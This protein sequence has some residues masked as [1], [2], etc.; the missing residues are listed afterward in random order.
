MNAPIPPGTAALPQTWH[1]EADVV[2]VG[3][4]GAGACAAIEAA[5][6]GAEVRVIDRFTG[7]GATAISGGVFYG[8]GGTKIQQEAG[9]EDTI[10]D[11]FRYLEFEVGEAVTKDTL[12]HF[13]EESAGNAEW[14]QQ[15]GVPFQPSLCPVKTSYPSNDYY[16]Y[17]SGNESFAPY[18]DHAKPAA[19]GHRAVGTGLPGA[20]FYDPLK[21][22]AVDA[23]AVP[24]LQ[25]KVQRLVVD[26][27]RVVGVEITQVKPGFA[28]LRHR[29][30][31][32]LA[33]KINPYQ[34]KIAKSLRKRLTRLER[35]SSTTKYIRAL[36][37]VVLSAGG[38]IY[39]RDM[40]QHYAPNYRPGMPLGT[41]G[42]D[43][44][45]I[46]L[47]LSA[48]GTADRMEQVSAWRFINP[49]EA[50]VKGVFVDRE[51]NR[52]AN[53]RLYGA[54]LGR[55]M[56]DD[57]RGE[58]MLIIDQ[59][60][61]DEAR[62]QCK[63]STGIHW[64]QQAPALINLYKNRKVGSSIEEL[65]AKARIDPDGLTK[66]VADYNS[67]ASGEA[68]DPFGKSA[69]FTQALTKSPFYAI[70]CSLDSRGFPCPTLTLGGL[71]VDERNGAV[72][73]AD[74]EQIPG[75]Y[76][77]G[78]NAVGVC[79]NGYVSGLSLADCVYSGRRA[80]ACASG[81]RDASADESAA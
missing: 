37:G 56:V 43:G 11:M 60:V 16:L 44:S 73:S 28:A 66:T 35:N 10:E 14:L 7:G 59:K 70:N 40:V 77:A 2:V 81:V 72:L 75:L 64:F 23:G 25:S 30:L 31:A 29:L 41:T 6:N 68:T 76:A 21:S 54:Q 63:G 78:R 33:I 69:E 24:V 55:A 18:R 32:W 74:R 45:G 26:E 71:V 42:C 9:V 79:S 27:G 22:A 52:Y 8:G 53:E 46:L 38:F 49:P 50:M 15:H 67:Y 51:G 3:F 57:H 5:E 58:G 48:G 34:P 19:R 17:Y 12:R 13:C 62:A 65:A 36:K 1:D 80:G 39:N 61:W 20:N 4:G 47:G